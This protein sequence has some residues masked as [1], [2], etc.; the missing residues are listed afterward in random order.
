MIRKRLGCRPPGRRPSGAGTYHYCAASG[1]TI[2][3]VSISSESL[4]CVSCTNGNCTQSSVAEDIFLVSF[5]AAKVQNVLEP[6]G[7]LTPQIVGPWFIGGS[8]QG[9]G[10]KA[11]TFVLTRIATE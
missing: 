1:Q 8:I 7:T 9:Q 4:V 5:Q 3:P 2:G 11:G 10:T 6:G